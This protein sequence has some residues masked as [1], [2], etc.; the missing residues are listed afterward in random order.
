MGLQVVLTLNLATIFYIKLLHI[1]MY[2]AFVTFI[3]DFQC[4]IHIILPLFP[5]S[6]ISHE[7]K[8]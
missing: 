8:T 1:H 7:L 2:A 6:R 5:L 4:P 3:T